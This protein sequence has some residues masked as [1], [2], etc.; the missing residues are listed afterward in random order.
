MNRVLEDH[1][2]SCILRYPDSTRPNNFSAAATVFQLG[3]QVEQE[4]LLTE[5]ELITC[6]H[7]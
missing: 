3:E 5:I 4:L 2:L 6:S 1:V 7:V